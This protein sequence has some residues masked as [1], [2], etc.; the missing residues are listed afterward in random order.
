MKRTLAI[1]CATAA[2]T[3]A[4]CAD[5]GTPST[6]GGSAG[7]TTATDTMHNDNGVAGT[8]TVGGATGGVLNGNDVAGAVNRAAGMRNSG[9]VYYD[10]HG[11]VVGGV[12]SSVY[13]ASNNGGV[14]SEEEAA[15]AGDR[16]AR[17]L[18]NGRVHDRDG[19]LGD[20]ENTH[21]NTL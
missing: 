17:M 5:M 8:G 1:L 9:R 13:R 2:L 10:R 20:G 15:A 16:Y 11:G 4:G 3:L 18:Q 12:N 14:L 6:D 7:G 19:L 21:W